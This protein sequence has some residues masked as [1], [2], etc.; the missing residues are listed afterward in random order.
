MTMTL[1][2]VST[3]CTGF[4]GSSSLCMCILLRLSGEGLGL[5][6]GQDTLPSLRTGGGGA[7]GEWGSRREV[8]RGEEME[9]LIGI[10]YK[11][12]K[13]ICTEKKKWQYLQ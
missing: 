10:I 12:I 7:E 1:G 6:T 5:P 4:L 8:G 2:F 3:V 11:V 9:I 13:K